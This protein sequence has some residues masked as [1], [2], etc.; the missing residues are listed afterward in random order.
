MMVNL[1]FFMMIKT[2]IIIDIVIKFTVYLL[3][4]LYERNLW[5]ECRYF[6]QDKM[7]KN[8]TRI[9]RTFIKLHKYQ[10]T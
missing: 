1:K 8:V 4:V 7:V 10:Q 9:I 3:Y 2:Q 6:M 5:L